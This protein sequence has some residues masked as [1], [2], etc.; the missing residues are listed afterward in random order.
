MTYGEFQEQY[1]THWPPAEIIIWH[2]VRDKLSEA[3]VTWI[4]SNSISAEVKEAESNEMASVYGKSI[5]V[6]TQPP[7]LLIHTNSEK[8]VA[9]LRLKFGED[10]YIYDR[11]YSNEDYR[12][13]HRR[14]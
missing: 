11:I 14:R 1:L 4:R 7:K 2:L 10:M 5:Q 12:N 3:D 8:Q 6:V 13:Y 9:A